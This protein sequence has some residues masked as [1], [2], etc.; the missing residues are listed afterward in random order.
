[1]KETTTNVHPLPDLSPWVWCFYPLFTYLLFLPL[2]H[3][4]QEILD[5][6][7]GRLFFEG[8]FGI[9]ENFQVFLLVLSIYFAWKCLKIL[10]QSDSEFKRLRIWIRLLLVGL[11][12]IFGEEMSWGQHFFGWGTPEWYSELN[13]QQE[14][15]IHNLHS[16]WFVFKPRLI[17]EFTIIFTGI[18]RPLFVKFHF[19]PKQKGY[20]FWPTHVGFVTALLVLLTGLPKRI[21]KLM[22]TE[23]IPWN[24]NFAEL[25]EYCIYLF[26]ALYLW[27]LFCRLRKV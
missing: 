12:Y 15:N 14:T 27:S 20:W 25:R 9:I 17:L 21:S 18:I 11:I 26:L 10:K 4:H 7:G 19:S 13:Y 23:N 24:I 3:F 22:E 2:N 8:E 16:S 5:L 6:T 1:M